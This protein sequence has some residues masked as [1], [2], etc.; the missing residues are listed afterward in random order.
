MY[1]T[2]C[3]DSLPRETGNGVLK[4]GLVFNR[5]IGN[6]G[7]CGLNNYTFVQSNGSDVLMVCENTTKKRVTET[8]SF[9][10][11]VH[12]TF[13]PENFDLRKHVGSMGKGGRSAHGPGGASAVDLAQHVVADSPLADR[14][15]SEL[16]KHAEQRGLK[17]D[18]TR[19]ELLL[20]LHPFTKVRLVITWCLCG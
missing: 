14:P 19:D 2:T 7:K 9:H 17:A 10:V 18:G 8:P 15:T 13:L 20:V 1:F 11:Q 12:H 3:F 4:V 6:R 5:E 16:R